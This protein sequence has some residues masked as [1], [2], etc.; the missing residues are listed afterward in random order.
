MQGTQATYVAVG[1]KV[2]TQEDDLAMEEERPMGR[3]G[4]RLL[5]FQLRRSS[6][7]EASDENLPADSAEATSSSPLVLHYVDE[8]EFQSGVHAL[9]WLRYLAAVKQRYPAFQ[10]C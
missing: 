8:R 6:G 7:I 4:G 1:T 3:W 5:L 10:G 2:G 9:C